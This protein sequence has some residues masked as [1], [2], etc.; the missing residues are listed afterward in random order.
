MDNSSSFSK[1]YQ[2]LPNTSSVYSSNAPMES[3]SDFSYIPETQTNHDLQF[4]VPGMS[5]PK[6]VAETYY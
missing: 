3:E 5:V 6:S 1:S 2:N 4:G